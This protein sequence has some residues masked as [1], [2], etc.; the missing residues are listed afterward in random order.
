MARLKH[1]KYKPYLVK[2][3]RQLRNNSTLS[4]IILWKHLKGTQMRGYDFHRQKPILDFICD[5]FCPKLGL[6]IEIDGQYHL[7]EVQQAKDK[8]RDDAMRK[9]GIYVLRFPSAAVLQ[10]MPYVLFEIEKQIDHIEQQIAA[11]N[12]EA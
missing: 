7:Q 5:F 4:E 1:Y 11:K 12:S 3:A 6:C 9:E 8:S 2:L 10:N